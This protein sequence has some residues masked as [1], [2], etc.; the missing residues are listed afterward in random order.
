M[1]DHLRRKQVLVIGAGI[2]GLC[3]GVYLR[4]CGYPVEILERHSV[5]GGLCTCWSRGEYTFETC[6][7][8]FTGA[9]P[10]GLLYELWHEVFPVE[11]LQFCTPTEFTRLEDHEGRHINLWSNV[12]RLEQELLSKA[13]EDAREIRNLIDSVR[14]LSRWNVPSPADPPLRAVVKGV[15]ALPYLLTLRPWMKITTRAY[16]ERFQNPL[17]RR[18]FAGGVD[19]DFAMLATVLTLVWMNNGDGAYPVG[20]SRAV[21][22]GLQE[23][24]ESLGGKIRFGSEV[25]QIVVEQGQAV[26]VRLRDGETLAADVVVSAADGYT[27]LY[28]LLNAECRDLR[29]ERQYQTLKSFPSYLQVSLGVRREFPNEPG[30]L[31]LFQPTPLEID[32]QTTTT[33]IS[34][35]IFNFDPTMAPAGKTALTCFLP[36]HNYEYWRSLRDQ[37]PAQYQAQKERISREVIDRLARR[38]PDLPEVIEVVDVATPATVQRFTNNWRG[39]MGGWLLTP[40]QPFMALRNSLSRLQKFY[41][42]GHWVQPGSGLP[43]GVIT[44]RKAVQDICRKDGVRFTPAG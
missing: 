11:R 18:F 22:G 2:G 1:T 44:A 39:S 31:V 4:K 9:R 25:E 41:M 30:S 19:A 24:Y 5:A 43:T 33:E 28:Q 10:G 12:D 20:G 3:A 21:I 27:T 35:R 14:R 16:A 8:W 7:H 38:L 42:V 34:V 23:R 40:G 17:L 32:P 36:T 13:P 37:D 29:A 26:G 6:L 15:R